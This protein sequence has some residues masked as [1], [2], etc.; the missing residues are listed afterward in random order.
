MSI[1]NIEKFVININTSEQKKKVQKKDQKHDERN[2]ERNQE[3]KH[4]ER[5]HERNQEQKHNERNQEQKHNERNQEQKHNERNQEQKH[6]ERN[7]EQEQKELPIDLNKEPSGYDLIWLLKNL[8]EISFKLKKPLNSMDA[9]N[10]SGEIEE[11]IS[12]KPKWWKLLPNS[13]KKFLLDSDLDKYLNGL[14]TLK[15]LD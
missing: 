8:H 15:E 10:S 5:N 6:D 14:D 3:Q 2:H 4:N 13:I 11:E 7:Q 9:L 12:S 1:I